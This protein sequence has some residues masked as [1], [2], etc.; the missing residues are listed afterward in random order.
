VT[1]NLAPE[2][3]ILRYANRARYDLVVMGVSRRPG[4]HLYFGEV[5]ETLL[6]KLEQS[7]LLV[8]S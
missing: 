7:I 2:D 8:S 5:A 6:Q 4:E 3:S 1:S